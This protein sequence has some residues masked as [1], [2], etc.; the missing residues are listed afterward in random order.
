MRKLLKRGSNAPF[1]YIQP[2][3]LLHADRITD[4]QN[5]NRKPQP[6]PK[7]FVKHLDNGRI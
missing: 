2:T 5:K 4:R 1:Y 3:A 7:K 6:A